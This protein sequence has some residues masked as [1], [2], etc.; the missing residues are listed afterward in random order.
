[1]PIYYGLN[2]GKS[3]GDIGNN[4]IALGNLGL[5]IE[6]LDLVKGLSNDIDVDELHTL[7][8]LVDDQ[9]KILEQLDTA[10]AIAIDQ[11][12]NI[13]RI[14]VDQQY[15]YRMSDRLISGTIKYNY[16]D[17]NAEDDQ[18]NADW[19]TRGADISTSRVS[20]WSPFGPED[21]PDALITYNSDILNK[22]EFLSITQLSLTSK[23]EQ[24]RFLSE[25][26]T[27]KV[28]INI[29]GAPVDVLAMRGIP[30][31]LRMKVQNPNLTIRVSTPPLSTSA[32]Q[33]IP[34]TIVRQD[35]SG[36]EKLGV[37]GNAI[38]SFTPDSNGYTSIRGSLTEHT[39]PV[40][41]DYKIYYNPSKITS[42]SAYNAG[43]ESWPEVVMPNLTALYL[44]S[45]LIEVM[46]NFDKYAPNLS[47]IDI[48]SNPLYNMDNYQN[49][50][51]LNS[52][53][54]IF[55]GGLQNLLSRL[56]PTIA[57]IKL[58]DSLGGDFSAEGLDLTRFVGLENFAISSS[59]EFDSSSGY[60]FTP[61]NTYLR[62]GQ[63]YPEV[64]DPAIRIEYLD[65]SN[66]NPD[67]GAT[68]NGMTGAITEPFHGFFDNDTV[69]YD[70][71][72][73]LENYT[74]SNN[75]P[76]T[77]TKLGTAMPGLTAGDKYLVDYIDGNS[78]KLKNLDGSALSI[79]GIGTGDRHTITK[80][81]TTTD[82]IYLDPTIGLKKVSTDNNS[83]HYIPRSV[84][85][86]P[87]LE[88]FI[89]SNENLFS[90]SERG[91]YIQ[92]DTS[93]TLVKGYTDR[94]LDLKTEVLKTFSIDECR[95][96]MPDFSKW[97]N[98]LTEI[99]MN[100]IT[101]GV[102][103]TERW[104][105]T[106]PD[107]VD[108]WYPYPNGELLT[109]KFHPLNEIKSIKIM[110]MSTNQGVA[111]QREFVGDMRGFMANKPLLNTVIYKSVMGPIF[112]LDNNAFTGSPNIFTLNLE[113]P[114]GDG[115]NWVQANGYGGGAIWNGQI[116]NGSGQYNNN[117]TPRRKPAFF[118]E[119]MHDFLGVGG[120][121]GSSKT[122]QVFNPILSSL[123][124]F[125]LRK[126]GAHEIKF[127]D[128]SFP[129]NDA[130]DIKLS[131]FNRISVFEVSDSHLTK[132]L[133]DP[134]NCSALTSY[135]VRNTKT[136]NAG[137]SAVPGVIY[138]ADIGGIVTNTSLS[139]RGQ[140]NQTFWWRHIGSGYGAQY[141]L[142]LGIQDYVDMGLDMD[143]T[144]ADIVPWGDSE[145]RRYSNT[146][147]VV[148]RRGMPKYVSPTD[149]F[150][151]KYVDV[152]DIVSDQ[153]YVVAD[154]GTT[155]TAQDWID[156]G[157][158]SGITPFV[159]MQFKARNWNDHM[160]DGNG[161]KCNRWNIRDTQYVVPSVV[162]NDYIR[163]YRPG[164][165]RG[166]GT[167]AYQTMLGYNSYGIQST[168]MP[169]GS[170]IQFYGSADHRA[171]D[172]WGS[173]VQ[174]WSNPPSPL[175]FAGLL[176]G[177]R[178]MFMERADTADWNDFGDAKVIKYHGRDH[179]TSL[180]GHELDIT[181]VN[182]EIVG[183]G[184]LGSLTIENTNF[185]TNAFPMLK[186]ELVGNSSD[187]KLSTLTLAQNRLTGAL[188]DLRNVN[189]L[190]NV[191][192][193]NN[194]FT[195]YTPGSFS[196]LN[197]LLILDLRNN[198]LTGQNGVDIINDLYIMHEATGSVRQG[199]DIKLTGQSTP[200][201]VDRL[202]REFLEDNHQ[203]LG[204]PNDSAL[205]KLET[206]ES[207]WQIS[208]D[209]SK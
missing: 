92:T 73:F 72:G 165:E 1:M 111:G 32:G 94:L 135:F 195:S 29:N 66:T 125:T 186:Q 185:Y 67:N 3:M 114:H 190:Q 96:S 110:N 150:V 88:N 174:L 181:N 166:T 64:A 105:T 119:R 41:E 14:D 25:V 200:S 205:K 44:G 159:G 123:T 2:T 90:G 45:N 167:H 12:Q 133:P 132:K 83:F 49:E 71:H 127:N 38:I 106:N 201:G 65:P 99:Y 139:W 80:W 142:N 162:A 171:R 156:L 198:S 63:V 183:I 176:V 202:S 120:P 161:I 74:D 58:K 68:F 173:V 84:M 117:F 124:N 17:F 89:M 208:I 199:L 100:E 153:W 206:L 164:S 79:S 10:S 122:A 50:N 87:R 204:S 149:A 86:S 75:N 35:L 78:F 168:T 97:E 18:S 197:S 70:V 113:L 152:N 7:A 140:S 33:K 182:N 60:I 196:P 121:S 108:N 128:S 136:T 59:D 209:Y 39:E 31:S 42:I 30:W 24:R 20:S 184:N 61:S 134:S 98:S 160:A 6:N 82:S 115:G 40:E 130:R 93:A 126:S 57:D 13:P 137:L 15:N 36:E 138:N 76:A 54:T 129:A 55:A 81:N 19:L 53:G 47:I 104:Q 62:L 146:D 16:I 112:D 107:P 175:S 26:A 116:S 145:S 187:K 91:R 34:I 69:L 21:N 151:Y 193:D 43:I 180:D 177:L 48:S 9:K 37:N 11:V 95:C 109:S 158:P 172:E 22:G 147:S 170:D 102:D 188:P 169:D 27:H 178:G 8:N 118:M 143:L 85:D 157:V 141:T 203:A 52:D 131:D 77:R 5:R 163:V 194:D 191:Y 103:T 4:R 192:L 155:T 28:R 51:N 144:N 56:P 23:P 101:I 154:L 207:Q 189:G 148:L 179:M 46:P